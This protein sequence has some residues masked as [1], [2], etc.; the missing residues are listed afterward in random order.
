ML[1]FPFIL[2][3]AMTNEYTMTPSFTII[4]DH[5]QFSTQT[6]LWHEPKQ[7]D[8]VSNHPKTSSKNQILTPAVRIRLGFY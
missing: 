6:M 4:N 3:H 2:D 8:S 7:P 5:L 1:R